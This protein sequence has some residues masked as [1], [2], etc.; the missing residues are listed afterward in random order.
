M[1]LLHV[2][3]FTYHNIHIIRFHNI[4]ILGNLQ[5][6][7]TLIENYRDSKKNKYCLL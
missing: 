7:K 4:R 5:N 3:F 6:I 1:I 2:I